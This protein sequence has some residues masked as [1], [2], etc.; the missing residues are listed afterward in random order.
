MLTNSSWSLNILA[1]LYTSIWPSTLSLT[2]VYPYFTHLDV[3]T[4]LKLVKSLQ[5]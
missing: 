2:T 5:H 1:T 4:G 3:V